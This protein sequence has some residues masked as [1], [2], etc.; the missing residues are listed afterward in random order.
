MTISEANAIVGFAATLLADTGNTN[1]TGLT[2]STSK[3]HCQ[4]L[5]D[6][7]L[8]LGIKCSVSYDEA[9]KTRTVTIENGASRS[10]VE[11]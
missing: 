7:F 5:Y 4:N 9:T 8:G 3:S 10:F 1:V 11:A 6:L 2:Y